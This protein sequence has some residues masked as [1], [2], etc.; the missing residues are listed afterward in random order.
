MKNIFRD[1]GVLSIVRDI[2][3]ETLTGNAAL[4]LIISAVFHFTSKAT[5]SK[6][7]IIFAVFLSASG[8]FILLWLLAI[9]WHYFCKM[10]EIKTRLGIIVFMVWMLNAEL[11]LALTLLNLFGKSYWL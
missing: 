2:V 3:R 11:V 6:L 4:G 9:T 5:V 8:I 1:I 10:A 7:D